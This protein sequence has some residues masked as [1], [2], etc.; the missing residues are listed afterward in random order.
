M[1]EPPAVAFSALHLSATAVLLPCFGALL[2]LGMGVALVA[3]DPSL[4]DAAWIALVGGGVAA[5]IGLGG[6]VFGWSV[7]TW[8]IAEGH[9]R[10]QERPRIPWL[11]RYRDWRVPLGD[12]VAGV[13]RQTA[14]GGRDEV[15]LKL[16]DGRTCAMMSEIGPAS[17]SLDA[18]LER[19]ATAI[20]AAGHP[21]PLAVQ[22]LSFW[23][24]WAG[25]GILALALVGVGGGL[26]AITIFLVAQGEWPMAV[27]LGGVCRPLGLGLRLDPP[28]VLAPT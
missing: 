4:F 12:V 18:F 5:A 11:G 6:L 19:L 27:Q 16:A 7:R 1:T 10:V 20:Q 17:L 3:Y 14:H 22:A 23:Q 26:A 25:L 2:L 8:T 21:L 9:L 13:R 24:T 15:T 28:P